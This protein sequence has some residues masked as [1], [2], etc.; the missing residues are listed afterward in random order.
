MSTAPQI[1]EDMDVQFP[2]LQHSSRFVQPVKLV[3][4]G[5]KDAGKSTIFRQLQ[6]ILEPQIS[7]L[8]IEQRKSF[9]PEIHR[10]VI[11]DMQKLIQ[12]AK[13]VC[14]LALFAKVN[15]SDFKDV[16][17]FD[18]K[19]AHLICILWLDQEIRLALSEHR[20]V[21]SDSVQYFMGKAKVIGEP[22]YIPSADD[23]IRCKQRSA[24][25]QILEFELSSERIGKVYDVGHQRCEVNQWRQILQN[26]DIIL[27]V[28]A[29]SDF[30]RYIPEYN[31]QKTYLEDSMELFTTVTEDSGLLKGKPVILFLNKVDLFKERYSHQKFIRCFPKYNGQDDADSAIQYIENEFLQIANRSKIRVFQISAVDYARTAN[32][33]DDVKQM[34]LADLL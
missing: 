28:T 10:M 6:R 19:I 4:L 34:I 3:L 31:H 1:K 22:G 15:I 14:D 13:E 26:L 24:G 2:Q 12:L 20:N 16:S 5:N 7:T 8:T 30:D 18:E 33:F 21:L 23:I 25:V 9:I 27:F 11:R 29:I 32:L 17:K